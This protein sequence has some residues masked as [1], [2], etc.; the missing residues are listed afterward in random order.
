MQHKMVPIDRF[1]EAASGDGASSSDRAAYLLGVP[2]CVEGGW[3]HA[4]E[5]AVSLTH[6]RDKL[7][8]NLRLS[9]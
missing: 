2:Y 6:L 3:P 1:E 4:N 7:Y 8:S 9:A 5:T